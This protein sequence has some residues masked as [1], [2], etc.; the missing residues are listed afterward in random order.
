MAWSSALR[1]IVGSFLS[2]TRGTACVLLRRIR[3]SD[4][5]LGVVYTTV[6]HR[7]C[8]TDKAILG[9]GWQGVNRDMVVYGGRG[10]NRIPGPATAYCFQDSFLDQP[11]TFRMAVG[12]GVEPTP[13]G[14]EPDVLPLD[15]PTGIAM[16]IRMHFSPGPATFMP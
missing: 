12:V 5:A 16:K 15:Y 3:L 11:D 7:R 2:L 1:S 9:H 4:S 14:S 13:P 10:G 8:T 6:Y